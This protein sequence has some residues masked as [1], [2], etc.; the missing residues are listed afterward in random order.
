MRII[1]IRLENLNSMRGKHFVS[2]D[3]E[4]LA[5]AGLFAITGPTGAGKSTLLDALTLALYGKA[6]RYGNEANPE[7]VMSRGCGECSA[8]VVFEVSSGIYRAV[9]QRH[10]ARRKPDGSLQ[11]PMRHIYTETGE[12]LAQQIREAENKIEGLLGLDYDR[13]L[14]SVLL[15]QGEFARFSGVAKLF[16]CFSSK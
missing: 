14:R 10:R 3:K 6:A 16:Y 11:P 2:L 4:P 13:F 5:S 1:S 7:H 8:E 9:W 12:P 15:A